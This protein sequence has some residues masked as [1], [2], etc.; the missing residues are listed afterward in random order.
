MTEEELREIE[1][2]VQDMRPSSILRDAET[3]RFIL[4]NVPALLSEVRRLHERERDLRAHFD[5]CEKQRLEFGALV[6]QQRRDCE[7]LRCL[8]D[9]VTIERD[10]ACVILTALRADRG[11]TVASAGPILRDWGQAED[12]RP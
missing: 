5:A 10:R 6:D 1:A 9:S 2:R 3:T 7:R 12:E 8:L 11:E 4:I